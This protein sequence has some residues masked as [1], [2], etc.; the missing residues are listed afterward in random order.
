MR[1]YKVKTRVDLIIETNWLFKKEKYECY[2]TYKSKYIYAKDK[3][4]AKRKYND[5]FFIP[6]ENG[7][8]K[9]NLWC[10]NFYAETWSNSMKFNLAFNQKVI[11]TH[12]SICVLEDNVTANFNEVKND[13]TAQ[14]FRDWWHENIYSINDKCYSKLLE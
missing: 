6:I 10:F 5:Y 1:L 3:V 4:E 7:F 11:H 2:F 9:E 13:M 8:D 14:D 12:A